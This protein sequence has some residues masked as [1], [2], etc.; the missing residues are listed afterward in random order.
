MSSFGRLLLENKSL[1]KKSK[2]KMATA[3]SICVASSKPLTV[4]VIISQKAKVIYAIEK[5]R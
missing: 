2:T 4:L 3:K 5:I 1:T